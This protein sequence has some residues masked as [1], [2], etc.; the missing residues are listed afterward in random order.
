MPTMNP[1]LL[2][3]KVNDNIE[4][5]FVYTFFNVIFYD[6]DTKIRSLELVRSKGMVKKKVCF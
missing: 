4:N 5:L 1:H 2:R 3:S 6:I